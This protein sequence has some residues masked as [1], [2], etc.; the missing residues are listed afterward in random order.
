MT[1][2]FKK[3]RRRKKESDFTVK[4]VCETERLLAW[5]QIER[6]PPPRSS[7]QFSSIKPNPISDSMALYQSYFELP[8][9][10]PPLFK[11]TRSR[12]HQS[13][14]WML[15]YSDTHHASKFHG[16]LSSSYVRTCRQTNRQTHWGENKTSTAEGVTRDG[17]IFTRTN[18][19]LYINCLALRQRHH[20][21]KFSPAKYTSVAVPLRQLQAARKQ[22]QRRKKKRNHSRNIHWGTLSPPVHFII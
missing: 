20:T 22:S 2:F 7:T 21:W 12:S 1:C 17:R 9:A 13:H 16:N 10:A 11:L 8:I 19:H 6:I 15:W 14:L 18:M 3:K 4:T 5:H